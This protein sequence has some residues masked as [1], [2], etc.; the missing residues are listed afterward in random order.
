[1]QGSTHRLIVMVCLAGIGNFALLAAINS[2]TQ[3][4]MGGRVSLPSAGLFIISLVVF[5]MAQRY[6]LITVTAEIEAII[7]RLRERLMEQVRDSELQRLEAIGR[8]ELVNTVSSATAALTVASNTLAFSAQSALLLF[9]VGLY[10]AYLSPLGF[11]VAAVVIGLATAT[12]HARGK[13]LASG[14]A[15]AARWSNRLFDRLND[16]LD[17]FKEIRLNRARSNELYE[18]AAE[19]SRR[20]ANIKI[21]TEGDNFGRMMFAQMTVYLLLGTMVFIVPLMTDIQ[22]TS[23]AKTTLALVFVVG[24]CFGLIQAI[25]IMAAANA[26]TDSIDELEERLQA[27]AADAQA[28]LPQPPEP[29]SRI[30]MRNVSFRYADVSSDARFQVGPLEFTLN[31]GDLVFIT[32]G[33]GSGKSTF[34]KLLAGLYLPESG[35]LWCDRMRVEDATR[36]SYRALIA[37]VFSDYHLFQ[38]PYGIPDLDPAELDR[39][40][41]QFRLRD[42][43]HLVD[44]EFSTLG[45]SGGQRKRLALIVSL[46]ERRPILLLDEWTAEQDPEF[47]RK[48]YDDVL[49]S[50]KRSGITVVMVTHDSSY[51]DGLT[52]PARRLHM[53]EGRFVERQSGESSR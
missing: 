20:A 5:I 45:L 10:V 23:V 49:P 16:F 7:H 3:S 36:D 40:L 43:T 31:R 14:R 27:A 41:A 18:D 46:L 15:E 42:K 32:G 29:F 17:G 2:G 37:G 50:L 22:G 4:S 9:F 38:R 6:V 19:I 25:P 35:E 30:E 1:M 11:A 44:G 34:L 12:Y 39:L 28:E 51:L 52:L 21:S 24:G 33:N 48:F 26:A 13:H 47:R 53:D 8:A